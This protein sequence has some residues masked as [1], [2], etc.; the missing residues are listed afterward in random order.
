MKHLT[1]KHVLE[2][3]KTRLE[4]QEAGITNPPEN[5]KE[6]TQSIVETLSKLP[7]EEIVDYIDGTLVDLKRNV[8]IKFPEIKE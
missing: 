5:I 4:M 7:M 6:I 8:I 1:A 2:V 3:Y